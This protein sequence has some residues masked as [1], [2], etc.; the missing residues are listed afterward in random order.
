[1]AVESAEETASGGADGRA[2]LWPTGNG[3]RS[4]AR[5]GRRPRIGGGGGAFGIVGIGMSEV[6][7]AEEGLSPSERPPGRLRGRSMACSGEPRP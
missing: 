4:M 6:P 1:M 7:R 3:Y 2:M 5:R